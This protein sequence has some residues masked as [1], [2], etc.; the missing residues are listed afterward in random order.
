MLW[1][2]F[3]VSVSALRF[4]FL[5]LLIL[6]LFFF[7]VLFV[8]IF[9]TSNSQQRVTHYNPA[10]VI[11]R[12]CHTELD[13]LVSVFYHRLVIGHYYCHLRENCPLVAQGLGTAIQLVARCQQPSSTFNMCVS[14]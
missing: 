2:Q 3:S 5:H 7:H 1:F 4:Y 14:K 12:F 13:R 9:H 6:P 10:A 11:S 8:S